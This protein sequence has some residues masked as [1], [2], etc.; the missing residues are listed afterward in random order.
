MMRRDALVAAGGWDASHAY[1]IDVSTYI[2][3]LEHGSFVADDATASTFR[4]SGGQ[5]SVALVRAQSEQMARL[6][7]EVSA[8]LPHAVS[9]D[10]VRRGDR[11]AR[12]L[13]HQR[14]LVYTL[15]KGRM[16]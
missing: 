15:L 1:A 11:R 9:P 13:A 6:H 14:R 10:D 2:R 12:L 4:L 5:W 3:V 7:A 16:R 8:R